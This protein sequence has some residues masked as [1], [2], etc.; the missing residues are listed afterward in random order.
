MKI[1]YDR[2]KLE[3]DSLRSKLKTAS[4]KPN[5]SEQDA[6][7]IK[8]LEA[9]VEAQKDI[10]EEAGE[11]TFNEFEYQMRK[12]SVEYRE[13]MRS[14]VCSYSNYFE[15]GIKVFKQLEG[16]LAKPKEKPKLIRETK[17]KVPIAETKIFGVDLFFVL[18]R[19]SEVG[20][21]MPKGI[22]SLIN[23]LELPKAKNIEG[24]VGNI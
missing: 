15:M 17:I 19:K 16:L 6:Q 22:E 3:Y 9:D 12:R 4:S 10:L 21:E 5:K 11:D 2:T 13:A 24:S 8:K 18:N 23:V 20:S 14:F 1:N 7:K